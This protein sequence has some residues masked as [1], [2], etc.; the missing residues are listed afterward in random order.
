MSKTFKSK[1]DLHLA[2]KIWHFLGVLLIVVLFN[3]LHRAESLALLTFFTV[4][5]VTVDVLRQKNETLN[6]FA[7]KLLGPFIRESERNSLAGT[8]YLLTASLIVISI[9]PKSIALLTLLF[10]ALADPIASF[11]GI[12][13]GKDKL[14]NHKTLQ[15]SLAAFVTCFIISI[16]FYYSQNLMTERLLLVSILSAL[17]GTL[18]EL[19]PIGK[20]DDNFTLP[21]LS[22]SLLWVVFYFLGGF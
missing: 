4:L 9:F 20:L 19:I 7:L 17:I 3:H 15:G 12:V 1:S 11:F 10:L 21:L 13:Y 6:T 14:I 18:S 2:R 5:F 8:T 22:S 16:S